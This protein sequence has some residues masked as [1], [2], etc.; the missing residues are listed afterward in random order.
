MK[1]TVILGTRNKGKVREFQNLLG[2]EAFTLLSWQ[3]IAQPISVVEDGETFLENAM[4]KAEATAR[5]TGEPSIADDS[6]LEVDS[7]QGRPGIHSARYAGPE[8]TDEKNY[9]KILAE[10]KGVPREHRGARFVCVIALCLPNGKREWVEGECR[11]IITE[12]PS[13]KQGFGYDPIF[14]YPEMG[15]TFAELS[16]EEKNRVSHR[17]EAIRKLRP[18]LEKYLDA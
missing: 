8:A 15:K 16:A 10:L 9:R 2:N 14:F 1:K 12:A 6:G 4:K 18:V 7:L 17:A 11:G 5:I 13:G 3:D